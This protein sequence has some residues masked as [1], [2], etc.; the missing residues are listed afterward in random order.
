MRRMLL[1]GLATL[2]CSTASAATLKIGYVD[3]AQALNEVDQG[4]AAKAQL[5]RDFAQKQAKLDKLQKSLK[6]KKDAFDKQKGT[7]KPDVREQREEEL[8][9]DLIQLQQT[10]AQLQQEL[11]QKQSKLTQDITSKLQAVVDRIGDKY[12]YNIILNIGDTVLYYKRDLDITE[13]VVR[14][15]N[16]QYGTK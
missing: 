14:E 3:M 8:Q 12:G 7:M 1:V 4:K 9:Q 2:V 5:K 15:Y 11:M 13:Q 6:A 16:K 10:Y